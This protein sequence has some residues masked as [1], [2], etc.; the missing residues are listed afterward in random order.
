MQIRWD[1]NLGGIL[2]C[3][4]RGKEVAG[5]GV[6]ERDVERVVG[7]GRERERESERWMNPIIPLFSF[8]TLNLCSSRE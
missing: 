6:G 1:V 5:G 3:M 8:M 4:E 7:G 2:S